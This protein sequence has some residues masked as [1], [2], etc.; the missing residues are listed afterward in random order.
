VAGLFTSQLGVG[1]GPYSQNRCVNLNIGVPLIAQITLLTN[2]H[3]LLD[4]LGAAGV[5]HRI[6]GGIDFTNWSVLGNRTASTN[7]TFQFEDN[8]TPTYPFRFY[9][10]V[11]P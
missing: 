11:T 2:R 6:Q 4:C 8:D 3:T 7:G 1:P 5:A 9:R 10:L